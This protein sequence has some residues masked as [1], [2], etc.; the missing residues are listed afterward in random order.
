MLSDWL[1]KHAR[2]VPVGSVA[3]FDLLDRLKLFERWLASGEEERLRYVLWLFRSEPVV[4]DRSARIADLARPAFSR[5]GICREEMLKLF[6]FG[7]IHHSRA[8]FD[9]FLDLFKDGAFDGHPLRISD[10][11]SEL[12]KTQPALTAELAGNFLDRREYLAK[13]AGAE[14]PFS[15]GTGGEAFELPGNVLN[16]AAHLDPGAFVNFLLPRVV[17]LI[18]DNSITAEDGTV[19]NRIWVFQYFHFHSDFREAIFDALCDAMA[20][21]ALENPQLLDRSTRE[22][23]SSPDLSIVWLLLR[24]WSANG[25]YYAD[26]VINYLLQDHRRLN[27]GYSAWSSGNGN[28]AISRAAIKASSPHCSEE[29]FRLLEDTILGYYSQFEKE[30]PKRLGYTQYLLLNELDERRRTESAKRRLQ[31]LA[32]KFPGMDLR[33]PAGGSIGGFVGSPIPP[34]AAIKM[35]DE[36]WLSAMRAHAN[37][38]PNRESRADFLKGGAVELS[39]QLEANAKQNKIRFAALALHMEADINPAYFEAILR[40]IVATEEK[41]TPAS[42]LRSEPSSALETDAAVSVVRHIH[43]LLGS[44]VSRWTGHAIG[45]LATRD[46]PEDLLQIVSDI[47]RNDPDPAEDVWQKDVPGLGAYYGGDPLTNGINTAR[48]QAAYAIGQLLFADKERYPQLR[49]AI[50]SLTNDRSIAVRATAVECLIPV[51][52]IDRDE[53]TRLFLQMVRDA[54]AVLGTM[55]VEQFLYYAVH[56][57]Y[58]L[59]ADLLQ[60]MLESRDADVRESA[61][62]L[63][64]QASYH[65][66]DAGSDLA[67]ALAGD[68][69][70]R[71]AVASV[72]VAYILAPEFMG[73]AR[74]RLKRFFEDQS[75]KVRRQASGCFQ[76]MSDEQLCQESELLEAFIVS[77]AFEQNASS[78]LMALEG[79]VVRLPDIICRIPERAVELQTETGGRDAMEA[80]WWTNQMATLVLRL[81]EQ[82]LDPKVKSRCLDVIDKMIELDLGTVNYELMK[83]EM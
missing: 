15:S 63:I 83:L 33:M 26:R 67:T 28:A 54:P 19:L 82:T 74:Q 75:E 31:E 81:Y 43:N 45:N 41:A 71:A 58:V 50:G 13:A 62:R 65:F 11:L 80:R 8:L 40:G 72:D 34:G 48:G 49:D 17:R 36:Q 70:C 16:D 37:E 3:W 5:G 53:A 42:E 22:I 69:V 9:L 18:K 68:E 30:E 25:P 61:T 77:P 47:A 21:V 55:F 10:R 12:G 23:E 44:K 38:W 6:E 46:L 32:R 56:S 24:A 14:S 57:H 64:A 29:N 76:K 39:R 79:S 2:T 1:K 51:L 78:L 60:F 20:R 52:N 7:N 4:K 59:L 66:A 73:V 27:V 35:T